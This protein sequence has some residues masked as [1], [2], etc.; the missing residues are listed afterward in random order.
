LS[1]H[2]NLSSFEVA[3]ETSVLP[4]EETATAASHPVADNL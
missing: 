4:L 3:T 2:V 1:M